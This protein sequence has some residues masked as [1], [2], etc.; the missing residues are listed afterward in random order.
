MKVTKITI[1]MDKTT[2]YYKSELDHLKAKLKNCKKRNR[3]LKQE[4]DE[5]RAKYSSPVGTLDDIEKFFV[6]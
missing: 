3:K 4:L 6:D 1:E 5:Y 2:K